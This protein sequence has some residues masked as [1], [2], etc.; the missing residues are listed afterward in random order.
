MRKIISLPV[1]TFLL[2]FAFN[3][4]SFCQDVIIMLNNESVQAKIEEV[5]VNVIKYR[6]ADNMD[7]PIYDMPKSDVYMIVYNN[8]SRDVI[9][10]RGTNN[11]QQSQSDDIPAPI[12]QAPPEMPVY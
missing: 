9:N 6:K 5:G 7:G 3:G 4:T 1:L 11:V 2:V 8:G 12:R 10:P